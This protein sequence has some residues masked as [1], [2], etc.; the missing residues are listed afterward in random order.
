MTT[1]LVTVLSID[2]GGIRGIIPSVLLKFLES[3]LQEIDGSEA[4]IADYF[5]IISGTSTGG[6]MAAMLTAPD[7]N[8]RPIFSA[9]D[10]P[11]FYLEESPKIFPQDQTTLLGPKYAGEYL[12]TKTETLLGDITVKQTL[13]NVLIPSFDI[14]I[15]QPVLFTTDEGK[16][17]PLLDAKLYDVCNST[18]AAPT[19]FPAYS[20]TTST[21][22][23][24]TRTFN[25]IDGAIAANNPTL[26][27]ITQVSREKYLKQIVK[28]VDT[29]QLLVLS[30]GCG[31]AEHEDKYTADDV[32]KWNV[33]NWA[34]PLIE[35]LGA[36]SSDMVDIHV[37]TLFQSNN[38]TNN[39]LR[40]QDDT[41][42]GD[43]LTSIDVATPENLQNLLEIG[44]NL[45]KKQVSRV[46]LQTGIYEPVEGEGTNEE[47]LA[48]LAVRLSEQRKLKQN[49]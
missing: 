22:E 45:L 18:S 4:R 7:S 25:L 16:V 28:A 14:F 2:G 43:D 46:N 13:T 20:F 32:S 10:I 6:L 12:R 44:N 19:I 36:A 24:S 30:L 40:I 34:R 41:L 48:K 33:L 17:N 3:K 35:M 39:Y 31:K 9:K 38:A 5:H 26:A 47:A 11:D 1:T 15:L 37:S 29:T 21:D 49:K 23:G 27:A 8:N 42:V